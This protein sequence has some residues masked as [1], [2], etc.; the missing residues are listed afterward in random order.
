MIVDELQIEGITIGTSNNVRMYQWILDIL[1][2]IALPLIFIKRLWKL[3]RQNPKVNCYRTK[4]TIL[5]MMAAF[6]SFIMVLIFI[7]GSM[8]W[9][10]FIA[11]DGMVKLSCVV[12]TYKID[13]KM[14]RKSQRLQDGWNN[15]E[16]NKV[17]R[18]EQ[19]EHEQDDE[20]ESDSE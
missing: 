13:I 5:A 6:T 7:I 1:L 8:E 9:E 4:T 20:Q 3:S 11:I 17:V 19:I 10:Y 15:V 12:F 2:V 18:Q 16:W 14:C